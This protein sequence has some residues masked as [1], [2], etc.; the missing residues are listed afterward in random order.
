MI[1]AKNVS[2][3]IKNE[4]LLE[5]ISL[6]VKPGE[7]WAVTGANG[8]GKSTFIRLLSAEHPLSAGSILFHGRE[9]KTYPLR[10]LAGKRAVLS[11]Q[12]TITLQFTAREIVLMGRYPFYDTIPARRDLAIV[13]LCLHKTGIF[14][15]KDRLYPTLSGGE[16]QR[17]Q[18]ARTLAQIWEVEN[19]LILLDEPTTGMDLLHQHETFRIARE[20]TDQGFSVIAV[21]HDLNQALQYAGHVLLLQ[22]GKS[23]ASGTPPAVLTESNIKAAFGLPVRIFHPAHASH[24]VIVPD[25]AMATAIP[26]N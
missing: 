23:F 25:V 26:Q 1:E 10:E 24:A 14:N 22:D 15:L 11:Q 7:F 9:L 3:R 6:T 19:G 16:Q 5:N 2:F 12:N 4:V 8:A 20:M 13:D 21:V 17:V 18:L